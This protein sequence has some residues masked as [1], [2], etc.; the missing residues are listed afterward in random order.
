MSLIFCSSF[1]G[2]IAPASLKLGLSWKDADRL[3]SFPGLIAPASLKPA[4]GVDVAHR[5][6]TVFRG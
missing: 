5:L 3:S 6:R 2:L 1:P 4:D